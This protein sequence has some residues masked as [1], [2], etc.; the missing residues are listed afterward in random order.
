METPD[1][2]C[3]AAWPASCLGACDKTGEVDPPRCRELVQLAGERDSVFHR[4]FDFVP[5]AFRACDQLVE[6]GIRRLLTSGK[7]DS[8]LT[9]A[10]LI[11]SLMER[12]RDQLQVMPGGGIRRHNVGRIVKLT[13][14]TQVHLG[15]S[16]MA[17]DDSLSANPQIELCNTEYL[18][19][20][21][22]RVV[23]AETVA[24]VVR[25]LPNS[26]ASPFEGD[27]REAGQP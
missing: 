23:S 2:F 20:G 8:A 26:A 22:H 18:R 5:D 25:E 27:A 4:A 12:T 17:C 7:A 3:R 1:E 13:G 9:G 10:P 6:L 15:A 24:E 16:A 19:R 21:R 14:C 11:R